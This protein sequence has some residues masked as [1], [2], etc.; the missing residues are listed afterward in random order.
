M[1]NLRN[2]IYAILR[3]ECK[4]SQEYINKSKFIDILEEF[5]SFIKRNRIRAAVD[6]YRD[7]LNDIRRDA[8]GPIDPKDNK[9]VYRTNIQ[10][11]EFIKNEYYKKVLKEYDNMS[12]KIVDAL[13]LGNLNKNLLNSGELLHTSGINDELKRLSESEINR[14]IVVC[15]KI[16][17]G[18]TPPDMTEYAV[19]LDPKAPQRPTFINLYS[20]EF[21][22]KTAGNFQ[23]DYFEEE[24]NHIAL[25]LISKKAPKPKTETEIKTETEDQDEGLD[26]I[27]EDLLNEEKIQ[28]EPPEPEKFKSRKQPKK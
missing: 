9:P 12:R 5:F 22:N 21:I 25:A 10:K 14:L 19:L 8:D 1:D 24:N 27:V 17:E 3:K 11:D 7:I 13:G 4:I 18:I 2:N 26:K 15:R 28:E 16:R 23:I 6:W 20:Q